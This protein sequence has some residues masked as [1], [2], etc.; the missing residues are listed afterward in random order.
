MFRAAA[1]LASFAHPSL[2]SWGSTHLPP[3][4]ST[5][6]FGITACF[7]AKNFGNR[8]P[9]GGGFYLNRRTGKVLPLDAF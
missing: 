9:S 6:Y 2:C 5:N 7:N 8:Q 4:Y 1:L 3:S